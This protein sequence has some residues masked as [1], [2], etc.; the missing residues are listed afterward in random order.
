MQPRKSWVRRVALWVGILISVAYCTQ[1][2]R[3]YR[4]NQSN[5]PTPEETL[6]TLTVPPGFQLSVYAA[7]P[8]L[9]NPVAFCVDHRNRIFLLET[10]SLIYD[11]ALDY[12]DEEIACRTFE[13]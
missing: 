3:D 13:D 2:Y 11:E 4:R 6:K 9:V 12:P 8:M 7:E 1:W 10:Q 5:F